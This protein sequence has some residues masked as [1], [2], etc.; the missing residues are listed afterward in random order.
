MS[1]SLAYLKE[2]EN[3]FLPFIQKKKNQGICTEPRWL[4]NY[5]WKA[6]CVEV[7]T[8]TFITTSYLKE[9]ENTTMCCQGT[10]LSQVMFKQFQCSVTHVTGR[11]VQEGT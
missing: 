5:G 3:A 10:M 4:P 6:C 8:P 2:Q 11:S 9:S 1:H 7:A